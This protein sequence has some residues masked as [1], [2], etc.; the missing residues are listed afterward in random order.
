MKTTADEMELEWLKMEDPERFSKKAKQFSDAMMIYRCAIREV[1]TKLEVLDDEFS[2]R[3]RRNPIVSI[4][5]RVKK[6]LSIGRKLELNHLPY[7]VESMIENLHDVAGIRVICAFID[8]I[9]HIAQM[10]SQQDD[11]RVLRI[12]DYI[13]KPKPNGYR[14]YHMIIEIPVFFSDRK[15]YVKVEV[16][17]RTMAMD[18]WA[19]LEH[20]IRYKKEMA[21]G[22]DLDV[23]ST[24]LT[25]CAQIIAQTDVRMQNIKEM[26]GEFSKID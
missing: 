3:H 18:F 23:I 14:S 8:D 19:S 16:Q 21:G 2:V 5:T 6:P 12:K 22:E 26:I 15:Q 25:E 7:T 11:I 13:E 10:L 1:Q 20:Q 17:I 4:K 24:E 9:Y